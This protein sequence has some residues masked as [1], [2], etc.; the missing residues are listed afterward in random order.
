M[1]HGK[2]NSGKEKWLK[3]PC[4]I[5]TMDIAKHQK[6]IWKHRSL[7]HQILLRSSWSYIL[8]LIFLA[9]C[10]IKKDFSEVWH[11]W[12]DVGTSGYVLEQPKAA[13]P[14]Q[15]INAP[16][17]TR[18]QLPW[19]TWVQMWLWGDKINILLLSLSC[20]DLCRARKELGGLGE[21]GKRGSQH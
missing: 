11:W 5:Y 3:F 8:E 14:S 20:T 2:D 21:Y 15:I 16:A 13:F 19:C 12:K 1:S 4:G 18:L 17:S 7:Q 10:T 9:D 6:C